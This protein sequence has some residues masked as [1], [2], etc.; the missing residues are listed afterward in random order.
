MNS[1]FEASDQIFDH[2]SI[3]SGTSCLQAIDF[4][5]AVRKNLNQRR[6]APMVA[7][8]SVSYILYT[9]KQTNAQPQAKKKNEYNI[10]QIKCN[11]I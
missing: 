7:T 11:D 10:I 6:L 9:H 2:S 4:L 5:G 8:L 3:A 1:F